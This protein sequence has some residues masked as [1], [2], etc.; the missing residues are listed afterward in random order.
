MSGGVSKVN[1][2][3]DVAFTAGVLVDPSVFNA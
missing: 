1:D 2:R 3:G